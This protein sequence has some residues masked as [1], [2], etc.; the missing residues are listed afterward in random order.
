[1]D[2]ATIGRMFFNRVE[3]YGP[4]PL[5]K[6]KRND[7]YV[8]IS[9]NEAGQAARELG[10]GLLEAG[11]E[12][13]DRVALLSE[14][15]PEW[16]FSD[17]G[18]L[19]IGG[20]NVPIYATNTPRQIEYIINDSSA[21]IL[22]VSTQGQLDKALEAK[23]NCPG[24]EQIVVLDDIGKTD[25]PMV[26]TFKDFSESG[27][28]SGKE[29]VF[30][31]RLEAVEPT[32]LASI[33]YTSGTTGDPKGVMLIHDNFLSNCRS[34][35]EI[36]PINEE[37]ICLSF[38]PLSHS[39][40]RMAGYYVPIFGGI[41]IAY[42]ESIDTVRDNLQEIRPTFMASVP[43]I[44]EKF[45]ASVLETVKA[46]SPFK[47]KIFDWSFSVG[48]MMSTQTIA[49]QTPPASLK[50][51]Y[52][53]ANALVF[54]KIKENV[55]GR[56][57]Y[58]I[59]G[60]APLAQEINEFFHALGITILEGYGLTET[61]PVLTTN[62]PDNFKFGTVGKAVPGVEIKIAN[63]GEIL[64]RGGNIMTG[65]FNK[66]EATAEALDNDGYF[67]TGDIGELDKDGFLKITDRKK[68][69]IVT[70]GGKNIAPQNIENMLKS[71]PLISNVMV[72]GD[73]RKFLSALITADLEKLEP[74]AR[75]EG[76]EYTSPEELVKDDR[77]VKLIGSR[78]EGVNKQLARYETIKRW[79]LIEKDFT[80]E[81]GE[82]TPTLKVKRKVVTAQYQDIID[83]F[84]E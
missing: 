69:I 71:D 56:L 16:A 13:G 12:H 24:L 20:I 35:K 39:F 63:D 53:I 34:V 73:K 40:E 30:N 47:Q 80:V 18:I 77:V 84:Y 76:I 41:T 79:K 7:S 15:R 70:A 62:T 32:D 29:D 72:H 60:G 4:R 25:Y 19:S 27:A 68:D 14:N 65:Y 59:S 42:A 11:I 83:S 82:L 66:P 6:V 26:A 1:M 48:G 61:S 5:F 67:H 55:G 2:D 51:K 75:R 45:H 52:S 46:G 49:K 36:L 44:Y 17:L 78:V 31:K 54:K 21:R 37:D 50:M 74:E 23:E 10:L 3:K 8:N 28:K 81:G 9:W 58:F 43:R 33:I 22:I 64:A 57:K 38:L